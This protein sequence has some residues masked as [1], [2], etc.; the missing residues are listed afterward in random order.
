MDTEAFKATLNCENILLGSPW[1]HAWSVCLRRCTPP[2][3]ARPSSSPYA[4]RDTRSPHD[5]RSGLFRSFPGLW[6]LDFIKK[7]NNWMGAGWRHHVCGFQFK[8]MPSRM[9][10]VILLTTWHVPHS[11]HPWEFSE[12]RKNIL[13]GKGWI[14]VKHWVYSENAAKQKLNNCLTLHKPNLIFYLVQ[15][16]HNK[17]QLFVQI[18]YDYSKDK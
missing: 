9:T 2:Q 6:S 8:V 5:W 15:Y 12:G 11:F 14:S 17:K 7:L 16:N 4:S 3:N 1:P 18:R 10:Q 13:S